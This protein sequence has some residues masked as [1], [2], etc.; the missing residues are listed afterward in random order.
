MTQLPLPSNMPPLAVVGAGKLGQAVAHAW[1][2]AGGILG[3]QVQAG[4]AWSPEGIVF[5]ATEP[6]GALENLTRCVDAGVPVVTGTTGWHQ[7]LDK[8]QLAASERGT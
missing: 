7:D 5:E 2:D 8:L 3:A 6:S 1:S 4:M